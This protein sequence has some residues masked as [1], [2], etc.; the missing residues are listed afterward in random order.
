MVGGS[1]FWSSWGQ[2]L[3]SVKT[4]E[5]AFRKVHGITNWEY[6]ERHTEEGAIFDMA[7]TADSERVVGALAS[8]YDFSKFGLL[9]DVGGG[10]G[11][12]LAA[13]LAANPSLRG[14]LFDQPH[15]LADTKA[16]VN[17]S[18]VGDRIQIVGGDF[19]EEVPGRADA[20][21]LKSILHDW[22]DEQ[23]IRI[24]RICRT[25]MVGGAKLLVIELVVL[26]P[27]E[28]DPAKFVDVRMLVMNGGRERTADEFRQLY[29]AAGFEL[30]KITPTRSPFSIIEGSAA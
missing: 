7:M 11:V 2:L 19:F 27:N 13:I 10:R 25:A 3:E 4:G 20:Y 29:T 23:A 14:I 24:L 8:G 5:T 30:C 12:L 1:S 9:V 17:S 22:N 26:P 16:I 15:V 6:R 28:P 21:M 18:G